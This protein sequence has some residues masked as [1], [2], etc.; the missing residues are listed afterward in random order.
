MT[1]TLI[2]ELL[3]FSDHHGHPFT[4]GA[5]EVLHNGVL[6][7]SRL[8]ESCAVINQMREYA[9]NHRIETVLFGGDLFHTRDAVSTDAFNLTLDELTKLLWGRTSFFLVGNH[10]AFD[11]EGKVHSLEV[12]KHLRGALDLTVLDWNC[13]TNYIDVCSS[14]AYGYKLCFVP[15]TENRQL[16][17]DTIKSVSALEGPKLLVAHLGMQGAKVGSDY[18]LVNDGDLS[19]DDVPYNEFVGCLFG[20]YHQHQQL[21]K[22]GWYIGASHQHTWG[23]VNTKRGFLHVRVYVDHIDFDFIESEAPRFIA[24][25][26]VDLADTLIREKD[27]VKV[28]TERKLT[29]RE[30]TKVRDEAKAENCEVVYVPPEIK[31]K[32]VELNEQHLTPSAMVETWVKANEEWLTEHLPGVE[33]ADLVEY[34]KTILAKVQETHG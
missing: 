16:A 15:H 11:R 2:D 29:D 22:N 13:K 28:F 1:T 31:L 4:Y 14:H 21:F 12:L 8:L 18:V 27:F 19:V 23:D 32:A 34:G 30:I 9:D 25:R 17:V 33:Q 3:V 5:R 26:D 6:H 10:D 24:V 7:N 20:H